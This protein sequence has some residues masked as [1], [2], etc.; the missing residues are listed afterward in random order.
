MTTFKY[1]SLPPSPSAELSSTSL[2]IQGFR[3]DSR[4]GR[5]VT[6]I[7]WERGRCRGVHNRLLPSLL[8]GAGGLRN[9]F[10]LF[11]F[12][13]LP[14]ERW[15]HWGRICL[16]HGP[17]WPPGGADAELGGPSGKSWRQRSREGTP[18]APGSQPTEAP[19]APGPQF[20]IW[21]NHKDACYP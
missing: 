8:G 4:V 16:S 10:I 21:S 19:R 13:L 15:G 11:L 12:F 6:I 18:Q 5:I 3:L 14:P 2:A 17:R 20:W 7:L 1:P 9:R